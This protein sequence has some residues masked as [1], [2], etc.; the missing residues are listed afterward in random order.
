VNLT[1]DRYD[2][3]FGLGIARMIVMFGV[4]RAGNEV[5][6]AFALR[7]PAGCAECLPIE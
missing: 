1:R 3:I 4:N 6:R 7:L 2:L 5:L